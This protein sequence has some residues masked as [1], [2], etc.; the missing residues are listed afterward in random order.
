M[1]V[2][3]TASWP[4]RRPA[5][6]RLV[7]A[8]AKALAI[9]GACAALTA[10]QTFESETSKPEKPAAR[11]VPD[12]PVTQGRYVVGKPYEENGV[13]YHPAEDWTYN[14]VGVASWYGIDHHGKR[15]ANGET[16]DLRALTAAHPTLPLPTR[17]R[18]TNIENG[19]SVEVR[20]ND[21]GPFVENRLIDL[22]QRA[23]EILGF[24][25]EGTARVRVEMLG[26]APLEM[27]RMAKPEKS[28]N[29][30]PA[31]AAP[32]A[33]VKAAVLTP[34]SSEATEEGE[35]K[36]AETETAA[37]EDAELPEAPADPVGELIE[38]VTAEAQTGEDA[39]SGE[40]AENGEAAPAESSAD[41]S[42]TG[43]LFIQAGAF[44]VP[45]NAYSLRR[46]IMKA[47]TGARVSINPVQVGNRE[48]FRVRVGPFASAEEANGIL[49]QLRNLGQNDARIVSD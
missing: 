30:L 35:S 45:E 9:L 8:P 15:T 27:F 49:A 48:F 40:A 47:I 33:E 23:A 41:S 36:P 32:S 46:L 43:K 22:S 5:K 37:E 28:T 29:D 16:F 1:A 42:V 7:P 2:M 3:R 4:R 38:K 11:A 25:E 14:E 44:A 18:V 12:V 17:V 10:C 19:K 24:K 21:R 13:R 26:R 20:V 39:P 31:R 6:R 34:R